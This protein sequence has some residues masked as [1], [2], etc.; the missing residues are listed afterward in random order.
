L[1]SSTNAV[2]AIKSSL[3]STSMLSGKSNPDPEDHK[4]QVMDQLYT[5]F[6]QVSGTGVA[7]LHQAPNPPHHPIS[8]RGSRSNP[9]SR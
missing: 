7:P 8:S 1:S 2:D 4:R 9:G 6:S 5:I 3:P